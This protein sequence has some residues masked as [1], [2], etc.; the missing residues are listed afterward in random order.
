MLVV[1]EKTAYNNR[2]AELQNQSSSISTGKPVYYDELSG[3][4]G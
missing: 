3:C 1:S 4:R 2:Y